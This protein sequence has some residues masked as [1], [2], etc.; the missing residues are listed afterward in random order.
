MIFTIKRLVTELCKPLLLLLL[1][2][3]LVVMMSAV[4]GDWSHLSR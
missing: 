1:L 4:A 3:V 2:L